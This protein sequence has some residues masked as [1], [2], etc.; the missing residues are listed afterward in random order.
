MTDQCVGARIR[1]LRLFG[2]CFFLFKTY[3]ARPA[4]KKNRNPFG[5]RDFMARGPPAPY[6][7]EGFPSPPSDCLRL[8]STYDS[9]ESSYAVSHGV[10][11]AGANVPVINDLCCLSRNVIIFSCLLC[12]HSRKHLTTPSM[13]KELRS[14][15]QA[16]NKRRENVKC[17]QQGSETWLAIWRGTRTTTRWHCQLTDS[18]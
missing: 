2:F 17:A 14:T 11:C 8:P 10:W 16:D 4:W 13:S 12:S 18:L 6:T 3:Y 7:A 15:P 5:V 9:M 1:S